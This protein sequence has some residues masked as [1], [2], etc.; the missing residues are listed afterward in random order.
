MGES[1]DEQ[2]EHFR[3]R[4]LEAAGPLTL[5]SADGLT[6]RVRKGERVMG[7]V[8]ILATCV[9]RDGPRDAPGMRVAIAETEATWSRFLALQG[10]W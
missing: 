1:L 8:V 2:I 9:N 10:S 5:V 3:Q 6:M 7:A 4:P